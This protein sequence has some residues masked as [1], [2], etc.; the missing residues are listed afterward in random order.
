MRQ[1]KLYTKKPSQLKIHLKQRTKNQNHQKTLQ[2][3]SYQVTFSSASGNHCTTA[4]DTGTHPSLS[5]LI[6][7]RT[8][9]EPSHTFNKIHQKSI[10]SPKNMK[11]NRKIIRILTC[12]P[13]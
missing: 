4:Q 2:S 1:A 10:F 8:H 9:Q 11:F 13:H 12:S 7:S 3:Y 6:S 5:P